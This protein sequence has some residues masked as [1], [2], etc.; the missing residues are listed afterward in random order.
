MESQWP[1]FRY[2]R[3]PTLCT[4]QKSNDESLSTAWSRVTTTEPTSFPRSQVLQALS[5]AVATSE[6]AVTLGHPQ[7]DHSLRVLSRGF[8]ELVG[9]PRRSCSFRGTVCRAL[10]VD[11]GDDPVSVMRLRSAF[12]DGGPASAV[13]TGRR[14]TG[15]LFRVFVH[16]YGLAV[17]SDPATGEDIW[18]VLGI[19]LDVTD[20]EVSAGFQDELRTVSRIADQLEMEIVSQLEAVSTGEPREHA[21][22]ASTPGPSVVLF[23]QPVH[24]AAG[25]DRTTVPWTGAALVSCRTAWMQRVLA[26]SALDS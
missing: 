22:G 10:G 8:E 26:R 11:G 20:R 23:T 2:D 5:S 4:R 19:H 3:L 15:E 25:P 13:L 12:E 7:G 18:F 14:A 9:W 16:L 24:R 21:G 1:A 17:G 6:H